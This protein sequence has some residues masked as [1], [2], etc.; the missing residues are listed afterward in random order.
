MFRGLVLYYA[1]L[2]QA[3][4]TAGE[5]LDYLDHDLSVRAVEVLRWHDAGKKKRKNYPHPHRKSPEKKLSHN[6]SSEKEI[7]T[8]LY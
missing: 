1:D 7:G 5:E 3:R 2:A 4:T 8:R 6:V